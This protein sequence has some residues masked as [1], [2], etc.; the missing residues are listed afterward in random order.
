MSGPAQIILLGEDVAHVGSLYRAVVDH[1]HV[2]RGRVRKCPVADGQG[3]AKQYI[4][5]QIPS[6]IQL[7][8]K[9]PSSAALIIAMDGDGAEEDQRVAEIADALD[10]ARMSRI[11]PDEFV[12]VVVPRRNIE[13][14]L[15]FARCSAIDEET[16]YKRG[17]RSNW[18]G[19]D[20]DLVGRAIAQSPPPKAD[21]PPSLANARTRL[22]ERL[23]GLV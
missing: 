3:D 23:S 16:D 10:A 19:T 13:T 14:W 2:P 4:L 15:T 7:L 5:R 20:F 6:E 9:G 8:R 1:L 21:A 17:R 22:R 18:S 11:A 12:V